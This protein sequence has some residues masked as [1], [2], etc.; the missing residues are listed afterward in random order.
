V[1]K[2]N[3]DIHNLCTILDWM[4]HR[5]I[6][7]EDYSLSI[8]AHYVSTVIQAATA[9]EDIDVLINKLVNDIVLKVFKL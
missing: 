4:S 7:L 5:T 1:V 2:N 9:T 8:K 6:E 3:P